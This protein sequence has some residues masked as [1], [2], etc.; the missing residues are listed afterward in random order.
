[1]T[2]TQLEQIKK[3]KH[4]PLVDYSFETRPNIKAM[5][6]HIEDTSLINV[7]FIEQQT[8][9]GNFTSY[10]DRDHKNYTKLVTLAQHRNLILGFKPSTLKLFIW[11]LFKIDYRNDVVNINP[12]SVVSILSRAAFKEAI[13]ELEDNNI[14]KRIGQKRQK[15]YWDFHFNPIYFFKGD[16]KQFYKDVIEVHPD[17]VGK[18]KVKITIKRRNTKPKTT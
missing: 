9:N 14:I 3:V 13:Q 8:D 10:E 12:E 17:Y 7:L 15:D 2:D 11:I 18:S 16:A 6:R 5:K 4:N 1:M